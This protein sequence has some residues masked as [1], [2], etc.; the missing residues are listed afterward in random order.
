MTTHSTV[1]P[2]RPRKRI[3]VVDDE[4]PIIDVLQEHFQDRYDMDAAT[5][6]A[7]AI[8]RIKVSPPDVVLLDI[9]VP[10]LNGVHV[11][12][13]IERVLA[14]TPVIILTANTDNA[15]AADAISSGAL[16]YTPKPL[17]VRYLEHLVSIALDQRRRASH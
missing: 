14:K 6:G 13:L 9:T 5:S 8:E 11:L 15:L 10:G 3:L 12:K 17:N 1:T 4:Q 2:R 16:S 7:D